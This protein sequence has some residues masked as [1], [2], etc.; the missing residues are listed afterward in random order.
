MVANGAITANTFV[1]AAASG[2]VGAT[3][4][5]CEGLALEAATADGDIIEVLGMASNA[6]SGLLFASVAA[7]AAVSN[8]TTETAFDQSYTIPANTLKAG[9]VISG[10][11]QVIATSTN[12]TDTLNVKLKI[13]STV[14]AATGA[15]DVANNDVAYIDYAITIR[16][17][18]ASGTLVATGTASL[19]VEGTAPPVQSQGS[20]S[21]RPSKSST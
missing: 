19:G 3:G 14:V 13:G 10:R 21:A 4:T 1:F 11:A 15:V 17:S 5:V 9:D 18:G 8:T 7:S 16:T 12:S 2:K 6:T 20:S